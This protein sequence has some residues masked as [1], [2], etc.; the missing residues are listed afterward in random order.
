MHRKFWLGNLKERDYLG[1]LGTNDR[2]A[3]AS[4]VP[5]IIIVPS[6]PEQAILS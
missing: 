5:S 1:D 2:L 4:A 3:Q 6:D